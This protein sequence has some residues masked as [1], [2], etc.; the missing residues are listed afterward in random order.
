M[1]DIWKEFLG[2]VFL[3]LW[4]LANNTIHVNRLGIYF[5]RA[6]ATSRQPH[7][8]I[9]S[10]SLY[11][12]LLTPSARPA[13]II[14]GIMYYRSDRACTYESAFA[15]PLQN[16]HPELEILLDAA[17]SPG[18]EAEKGGRSESNPGKPDEGGISLRLSAA[19]DTVDI[20]IN[21]VVAVD[22]AVDDVVVGEMSAH[23]M[24]LVTAA[25]EGY[26][27]SESLLRT[28]C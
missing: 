6:H 19:V 8:I 28:R 1:L 27:G 4:K 3:Y 12:T 24:R 7:P 11:H 14:T 9:V 22:T 2:V 16:C 5:L 17:P 26:P 13:D 20:H 25:M 23:G 21:V 10:G 18:E 15:H